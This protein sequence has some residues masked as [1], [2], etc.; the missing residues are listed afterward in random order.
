MV[1]NE[2]PEFAAEIYKSYLTCAA[3]IVKNNGGTITAYDGDRIMAVFIG[4]SKNSAVKTALNINY[5]VRKIINPAIPRQYPNRTYRLE[6]VIGIDTSS[7]E[8][9]REARRLRRAA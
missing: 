6:H 5:A 4:N 3:R 8:A 2:E 9:A 7:L 1:D